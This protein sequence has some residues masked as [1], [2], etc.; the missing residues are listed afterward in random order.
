MKTIKGL[1]ENLKEYFKDEAVKVSV[2]LQKKRSLSKDDTIGKVVLPLNYA[3]VIFGEYEMLWNRM[4]TYTKE[5][6]TLESTDTFSYPCISCGI[7]VPLD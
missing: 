3:Y 1:R 7:Y 5:I 4:D 6:E 2:V